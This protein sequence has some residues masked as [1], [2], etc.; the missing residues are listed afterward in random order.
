MTKHSSAALVVV[1]LGLLLALSASGAAQGVTGF[2]FG[3]TCVP[4]DAV[5]YL[6]D[7]CWTF[8]AEETEARLVLGLTHM[9]GKRFSLNGSIGTEDAEFPIT[10][11]AIR[12][13]REWL[14]TMTATGGGVGFVLPTDPPQAVDVAGA[15]LFYAVLDGPTL[16]GQLLGADVRGFSPES[17][18]FSSGVRFAGAVELS[19]VP[20]DE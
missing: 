12:R 20:C 9:G 7:F 13:G 19:N 14:I 5:A 15:R 8:T 4:P 11:V 2:C 17:E 18:G 6:G 10:G 1:T 16:N 3:E